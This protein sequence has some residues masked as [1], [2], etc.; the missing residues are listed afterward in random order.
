MIIEDNTIPHQQPQPL[1]T[2]D[3]DLHVAKTSTKLCANSLTVSMPITVRPVVPIHQLEFA[4]M[5]GAPN[6][7]TRPQPWTP[8]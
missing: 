3:Q 6:F 7:S 4:Q 1:V 2:H 8:I 5:Q